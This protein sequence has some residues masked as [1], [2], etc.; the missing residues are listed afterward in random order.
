MNKT[1]VRK[2]IANF[3]ILKDLQVRLITKILITVLASTAITLCSLLLVYF[4]QFRS[5]LFYQLNYDQE[6]TKENILGIILPSL[7]ISAVVNILVGLCVGLYAS[8]KY[9]VPIYKLEQ[10]AKLLRHGHLS[11][12]LMFREREEMNELSTQC[13]LLAEEMREKIAQISKHVQNAL[14]SGANGEDITAIE[15]I[16]STFELDQDSI[17]VHTGFYAPPPG[18]TPGNA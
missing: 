7:L 13:N 18:H 12:R 16:V 11:A 4:I 1:F 14:K 17:H 8:R 3:F 9:A 6:L 5:V 15:E 10:W 2:P